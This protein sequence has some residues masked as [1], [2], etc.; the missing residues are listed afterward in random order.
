MTGDV[1]IWTIR[2]NEILEDTVLRL[3]LICLI[4]GSAAN[5]KNLNLRDLEHGF[6]FENNT[7]TG[8]YRAV[9]AGQTNNIYQIDVFSTDDG[10]RNRPYLQMWFNEDAQVLRQ[11]IN[12]SFDENAPHDCYFAIGQCRFTA[13]WSDGETTPAI[14][15]THKI[16]DVYYR[17]VYTDYDGTSNFWY[18]DCI[19]PDKYGFALDFFQIDYDGN[20]IWQQRTYSTNGDTSKIG[21]DKIRNL[22]HHAYNQLNEATS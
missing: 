1:N 20:E 3:V 5:A 15:A 4:I 22:C 10:G 11:G 7:N 8:A 19:V 14:V 2:A 13:I 17:V 12:A 18:M 6:Y 16:K 9:F 21:I